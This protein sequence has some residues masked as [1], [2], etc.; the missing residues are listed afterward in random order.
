MNSAFLQKLSIASAK[1]D[2]FKMKL[3]LVSILTNVLLKKRIVIRRLSAKTQAEVTNAVV[4][5][6]TTE[7]VKFA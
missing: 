6:A 2:L 3:V 1:L 4:T 5:R 7:M